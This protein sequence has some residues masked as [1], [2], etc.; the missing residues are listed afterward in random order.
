MAM[1]LLSPSDPA[2]P[3]AGSVRSAV[4]PVVAS[5]MVAPLRARAEV[6]E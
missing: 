1:S 6:E 2:A 4:M 5:A 3:G